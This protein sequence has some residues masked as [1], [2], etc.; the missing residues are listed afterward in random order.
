MKSFL[1]LCVTVG[2]AWILLTLVGYA[3]WQQDLKY[4]QPTPKPAFQ[5]EVPFGSEMDLPGVPR[6]GDGK[7]LF[8]HFFNPSCPCSRFNLDHVRALVR[9]QKDRVHFVAVLQGG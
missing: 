5:K 1:R 9:Q 8:L 6:F 3:F 7:P 2:S 4:S